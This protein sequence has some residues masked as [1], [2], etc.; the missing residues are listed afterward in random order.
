MVSL[1]RT[2]QDLEKRKTRG[3]LALDIQ[4]NGARSR[5]P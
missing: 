4:T 5:T 1:E 3:K 2:G